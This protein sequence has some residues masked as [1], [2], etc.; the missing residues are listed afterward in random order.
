MCG[1]ISFLPLTKY[2]YKM[3][4]IL[5]KTTNHFAQLK[6]RNKIR[7]KKCLVRAMKAYRGS[8][9]GAPLIPELSTRWR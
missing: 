8:K 2:I 3:S 4:Y 9:S 1:A 6:K 5:H 7:V